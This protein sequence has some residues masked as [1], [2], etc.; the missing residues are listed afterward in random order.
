MSDFEPTTDFP[1]FIDDDDV[2]VMSGAA[3]RDQKIQAR[4][5]FILRVVA[6]VAVGALI[7]FGIQWWRAIVAVAGAYFSIAIGI[8][9]LGAF[10]RPIPEA[11]PAGELRRVKLTYRCSHCGSEIR[12][13]LANDQ[14]PEPPRHCTDDMELTTN[15]EDVL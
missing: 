9:A 3:V 15:L 8:A 6:A 14:V 11:P 4:R 12:M 1:E 5:R 7:A 13:T 2:I 10:A